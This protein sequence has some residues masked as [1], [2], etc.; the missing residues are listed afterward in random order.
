M[1]GIAWERAIA[2][3][4]FLDES[5]YFASMAVNTGRSMIKSFDKFE[6]WK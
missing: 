6:T 2:S 5:I 1:Q 3:Q 4:Q